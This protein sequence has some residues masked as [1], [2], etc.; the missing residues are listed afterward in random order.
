MLI[1]TYSDVVK[2]AAVKKAYVT[3]NSMEIT[4]ELNNP[5][6]FGVSWKVEMKNSE[7]ENVSWK[8]AQANLGYTGN[9]FTISIPNDQYVSGSLYLV[10]ILLFN[11]VLN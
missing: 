3:F 11:L 4:W 2:T 1:F 6:V 7:T 8:F 10:K 9:V 5:D